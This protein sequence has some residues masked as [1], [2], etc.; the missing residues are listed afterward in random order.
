MNIPFRRSVRV[1]PGIRLTSRKPGIGA[2]LGLW[3]L[4]GAKQRHRARAYDG[5]PR[6]GFGMSL[7][8]TSSGHAAR[9]GVGFALA[10]AAV[11]VA[12]GWYKL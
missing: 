11:L 3:R 4:K 5:S 8:P 6:R 10:L 9:F 7:Y 2:C 1:A 12:L